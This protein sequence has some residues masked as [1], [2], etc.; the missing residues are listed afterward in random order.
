[1][2]GKAGNAKSFPSHP[3]CLRQQTLRRCLGS[4]LPGKTG[5]LRILGQR[6]GFWICSA[7]SAALVRAVGGFTHHKE[8]K[9][10]PMAWVVPPAGACGAAQ[11]SLLD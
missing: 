5:K 1:M 7:G 2:T 8:L 3:Q 4:V 11:N 6:D 10:K 9:P